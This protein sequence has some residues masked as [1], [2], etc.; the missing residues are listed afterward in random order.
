MDARKTLSMIGALLSAAGFANAQQNTL[1]GTTD[2]TYLSS[3]IR[4]G[5]DI[6]PDDHS[7]IQPGIYIDLGACNILPVINGRFGQ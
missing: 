6:Y 3:Y 7:A 5:F 1:H 2:V 4:R